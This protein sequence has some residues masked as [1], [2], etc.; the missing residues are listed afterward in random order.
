ML[1]RTGERT[2]RVNELV[3]L[4]KSL[5][6]LPDKFAGLTDDETRYNKRFL[7]ILMDPSVRERFRF[8]SHVIHEIRSFLHQHRFEEV[9]TPMLQALACGANASAFETH[10]DALDRTLYLRIAPETYLKRLMIAGF[11]RVYEIG[12][13]FRNEGID[14]SHLQEFTML[15]WYV[16]YWNMW[17]NLQFIHLLLQSVITNVRSSLTVELPEVTINFGGEWPVVTY[18]DLVE[19]DCGIDILAYNRV[20]ELLEVIRE[21]NIDI[22]DVKGASLATVIDKLYKKVSRPKLIQP[23]FIINYPASLLPLARPND[24]DPRVVDAFQLLVNGW[25]IVKAYSELCD[26]LLQRQK[27]EEQSSAKLAGDEEA[28]QLDEPYLEAM[29]HGMPPNSGLGLGIDRLVC[30]LTGQTN[31]KEVILFP[32]GT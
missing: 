15:E 24:Q 7:D 19:G 10:H 5:L 31:L 23:T 17:D 13:N 2:V 26:P 30:L 22:G 11:D 28:M 27:L 8:R 3:L 9:E 14:R 1:T 25:E 4:S 21:K 32:I 20:E 6:P 16:A 12:K 29:E 18:Q